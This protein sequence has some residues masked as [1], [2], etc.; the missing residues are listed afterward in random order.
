VA[1]W[2][3]ASAEVWPSP[4]AAE[5]AAAAESRRA[6]RAAAAAEE[7]DRFALAEQL[8]LLCLD[9]MTERW[10]SRVGETLPRPSLWDRGPWTALHPTWQ[11]AAIGGKAALFA[12]LG[13]YT[14]VARYGSLEVLQWA[15]GQ[16]EPP[17]LCP[18]ACANAA[19]GGDVEMLMWMRG[20][21][22]PFPWGP[23]PVFYTGDG[24]YPDPHTHRYRQRQCCSSTGTTLPLTT[25][26]PQSAHC[27]ACGRIRLADA[28]ASHR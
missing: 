7:E 17:P 10:R 5:G 26:V 24:N 15:H 3:R 16:S 13:F 6:V 28:R 1:L 2:A 8:A 11:G 22:T 25:H 9:G 19:L 20:L 4:M 21:A 27:P 12:C 14:G 23:P 18:G